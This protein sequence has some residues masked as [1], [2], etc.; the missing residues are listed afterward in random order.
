[1]ENQSS[2]EARAAFAAVDAGRAA[3]AE[4]LITPLWY[5]PILGLLASGYLLATSSRSTIITLIAIPVFILGVFA[6]VSAYKKV[7]GVWIS[8]F[9]AGRAS[10]W[11]AA[12]G[13]ALVTCFG[14][15]FTG[16]WPPLGA[17]VAAFISVNVFGLLFD[18]TLRASLR[19]GTVTIPQ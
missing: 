7:T 3:A 8:G 15:V 14:L 13:V 10:W 19:D 5:H 9:S 18:R 1:M 2:N 6:L 12:M 16:I 4:R 11:A 17:A